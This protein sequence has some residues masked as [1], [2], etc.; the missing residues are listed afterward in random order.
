MHKLNVFRG[1][2]RV[3]YGFAIYYNGKMFNP[4]LFD[5]NGNELPR[6]EWYN[7]VW[8]DEPPKLVVINKTIQ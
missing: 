5:D 7:L 3:G 4:T 8:A 6:D 2:I 1:D